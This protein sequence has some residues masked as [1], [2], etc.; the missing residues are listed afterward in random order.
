MSMSAAYLVRRDCSANW[1]V[2]R[3]ETFEFDDDCD[4]LAWEETEETLLLWEDFSNYN[5]VNL[6]TTAAAGT[7]MSCTSDTH[8]ETHEQV[9]RKSPSSVN[10]HV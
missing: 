1:F 6:T 5:S 9:G 7:T 8:G 10:K 3:R 4:S 2:G